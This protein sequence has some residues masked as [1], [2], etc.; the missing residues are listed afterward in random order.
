MQAILGGIRGAPSSAALWTALG[1]ALA[2]HD[3]Q[4]SAPARFA[5]DQAI[6][7]APRNPGPRLFLGLAQVR[8]NDFS[9]AERSWRQALASTAPGAPYRAAIADRLALLA[10]LNEV[11]RR[12][13][14]R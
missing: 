2:R 1:D 12:R 13:P 6:R 10:G 8:T 11:M 3:R 4:L 5:F 14:E 9:A 7:L